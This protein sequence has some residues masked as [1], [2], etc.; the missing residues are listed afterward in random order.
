MVCIAF[1]SVPFT[2]AITFSSGLCHL[3]KGRTV[4]PCLERKWHCFPKSS[5]YLPTARSDGRFAGDSQGVYASEKGFTMTGLGLCLARAR[6][7]LY[8]SESVL[9]GR[10]P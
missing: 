3:T 4:Y 9:V 1:S 8:A 2:V 10:S 6:P 5:Q 7:P